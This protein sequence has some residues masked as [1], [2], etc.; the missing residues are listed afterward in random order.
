MKC[1]S[2]FEGNWNVC[3]CVPEC[4]PSHVQLTCI[5]LNNPSYHSSLHCR[6]NWIMIVVAFQF[7][8][9]ITNHPNQC[10]RSSTPT[11]FNSVV[12]YFPSSLLVCYFIS[13]SFFL[14]PSFPLLYFRALCLRSSYHFR[15]SLSPFHVLPRPF[16]ISFVPFRFRIIRV[17]CRVRVRS[18]SQFLVVLSILSTFPYHPPT[19]SL[20]SGDSASM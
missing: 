16:F 18:Y 14:S 15:L 6:T 10:A 20:T 17:D 1:A 11:P 4:V 2:L 19:H 8:I 5:C 7:F 9:L 12:V 13:L 3:V